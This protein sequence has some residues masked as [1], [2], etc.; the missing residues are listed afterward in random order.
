MKYCILYWFYFLVPESFEE[1]SKRKLIEEALSDPNTKLEVWQEFATSEYGL[2][3]GKY[4]KSQK[5]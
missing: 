2:I 3:S 5:Y 4:E 1:Q